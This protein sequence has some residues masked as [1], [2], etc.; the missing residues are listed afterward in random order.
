MKK[1]R[2]Q[3]NKGQH[4]KIKPTD[5]ESEQN[6]KSPLPKSSSTRRKSHNNRSPHNHRRTRTLKSAKSHLLRPSSILLS[7][8]LFFISKS[9]LY[10]FLY[11]SS[12]HYNGFLMIPRKEKRMISSNSTPYQN[13][14][15]REH[16]RAVETGSKKQNPPI[17]RK[18]R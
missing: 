8:S 14:R 4:E 13:Q 16:K 6:H 3:I 2:G 12:N 5:L 15:S 11:T 1:S 7:R 10:P 18:P 9:I 17:R